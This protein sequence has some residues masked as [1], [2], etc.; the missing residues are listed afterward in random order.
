MADFSYEERHAVARR[1]RELM[2]LDRDSYLD[3]I[4][5]QSILDELGEGRGAIG[6]VIA[7]LID[8]PTCRNLALKPADEFL[9]SR[10]GE[11]VDITYVEN[12]D[13]Y[14]AK[15]CPGCRA[16]VVK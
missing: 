7:D 9:C 13:D 15:Y 3:N 10:C 12:A 8:P 16:K 5:L 2:L 14:H 4:L 1:M 6:L 11:H